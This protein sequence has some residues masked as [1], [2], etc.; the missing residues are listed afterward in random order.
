MILSQLKKNAENYLGKKVT[1]AIITVPAYFNDS[2][3]QA[4]KDA[5]KIAGLE[6]LRIINEPTAAAIAYGLDK[7]SPNSKETLILVYD[8]GGGTLDVSLLVIE[9]NIFEVKGV[10]GDTFLGG[11]DI[12]N[13][14]VDFLKNDFKKKSNIDI[15]K[16][17]K[18]LGKLKNACENAKRHLSL[19]TNTNIDIDSLAEGIDYSY[20][21]TRA[22]FEQLCANIFKKALDPVKKVLNDSGISK[23]NINDIILI[24]GSTRIPKIQELLKDFFGKELSKSLNPDEAVAYGASV[25]AASIT[26]LKKNGPLLVDVAPLSLGIETAGGIN[27]ILIKRNTSIPTKK[28]QLFSTFENNQPAA[29]IKIY[30]GER[31]L[32]KDN[33]LLGQFILKK[34]PP[35]PKGVPKIKITY[36]IDVNGILLVTA[37]IEGSDKI[38]KLKIDS[39]R[40][41]LTEDEIK[42][43][44]DDAEKYKEFD[45]LEKLRIMNKNK[46]LDNII[47]ITN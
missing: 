31:Q 8:F 7:L 27:T 17:P 10:S 11:E 3:R 32:T 1:K 9:N 23:E 37:V 33:R 34:I 5:G 36:D 14:L 15:S 16:N 12:D 42:K 45:E 38:Q 30:E 19:A 25:Q 24:G 22:K 21:L 35:A 39:N 2:Q 20:N 29:T 44:V 28:E 4:T 40:G 46:L 47:E 43:M 26:G 41:T 18:A 13:I 6:V